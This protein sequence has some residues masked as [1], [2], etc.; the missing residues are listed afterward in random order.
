MSDIKHLLEKIAEQSES[1]PAIEN[2]MRQFVDAIIDR[3]T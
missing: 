2:Q 3:I 1:C